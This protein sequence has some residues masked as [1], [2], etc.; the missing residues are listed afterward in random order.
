MFMAKTIQVRN[1]P[2]EVHKTLSERA[3]REHRSLSDLVLDEIVRVGSRP[4]MKEFLAQL[5]ARPTQPFDPGESAADAIR[6]GR[7]DDE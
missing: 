2:D 5:D 3:A 4:T 1:V 6:A 7:G